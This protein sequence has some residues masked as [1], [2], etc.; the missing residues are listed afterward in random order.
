MKDEDTNKGHYHPITHIIRSSVKAFNDM[1]FEV[2][3]GPEIEMAE[4]NFDNLNI[5]PHHPAREEE[6]TFWL[7]NKPGYLLRT[8]TSAHQVSY[9]RNNTPPFKMIS[10]GKVYRNEATDSTHDAQFY[11]IEGLAVDV[12]G[13]ITLGHLK[14]TLFQYIEQ[15]FG[16]VEKRVRPAYFPFVEPGIEFDMK[17][18][19][20]WLEI[21]GA[22]MVHPN[23]LEN[24]GLNPTK[25]AGLAFGIGVDRLLMI[26]YG[27]DDIRNLY[28]G[29]LRLVNQF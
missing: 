11:Q 23:V 10:V 29:D 20:K 4:N 18:N 21:L 2:S 28:K 7:K 8:Q 5:P 24:G 19:E 9:M 3:E 16:D 22:G 25:Y 27:I 13:E 12:K 17:F 1:G 6:D 15:L 14:G 26:K